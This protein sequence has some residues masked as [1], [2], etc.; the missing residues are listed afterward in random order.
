VTFWTGALAHFY[1]W[2]P[3]FFGPLLQSFIEDS[4]FLLRNMGG[5]KK[6]KSEAAA[7]CAVCKSA[8]SSKSHVVCVCTRVVFCSAACQQRGDGSHA[9][10]GAPN[11]RV[12]LAVRARE[13]LAA[14]STRG[15]FDNREGRAEMQ[16]VEARWALAVQGGLSGP[17]FQSMCDVQRPETSRAPTKQ[18][19]DYARKSCACMHTCTPE[20]SHAYT[21]KR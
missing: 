18:A 11:A 15:H 6:T 19:C 8:T 4:R 17:K 12:D 3:F 13:M 16:A 1:F 5:K 14:E 10:Q 2:F 9:C 20:Q 21:V 7:V